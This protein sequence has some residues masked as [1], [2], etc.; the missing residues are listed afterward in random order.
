MEINVDNLPPIP[1]R[2]LRWSLFSMY[3]NRTV[4]Y[5]GTRGEVGGRIMATLRINIHALPL[6]WDFCEAPA[7]RKEFTDWLADNK[8]RLLKGCT[9]DRLDKNPD[10]DRKNLLTPAEEMKY[11]VEQS[12]KRWGSVV[13]SENIDGFYYE[14]VE[15]VIELEV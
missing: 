1:S 4:Y 2:P 3:S 6:G 9:K 8:K 14:N 10:F 7:S 13:A 12:V 5:I 11:L 15:D